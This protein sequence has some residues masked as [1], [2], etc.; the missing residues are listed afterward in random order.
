[1]SHTSQ[2]RGLNPGRPGLF[3]PC[4]RLRDHTPSNSETV[5]P[6]RTDAASRKTVLLQAFRDD[7]LRRKRERGDL[8]MVMNLPL[9]GRETTEKLEW[10]AAEHEPGVQPVQPRPE[11]RDQARDEARPVGEARKT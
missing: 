1:M 7:D 3:P 8:Q 11:A 10:S 2:R 6:S 4:E 5:R 9:G